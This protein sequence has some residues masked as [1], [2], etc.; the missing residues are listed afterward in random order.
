MKELWTYLQIMI[1]SLG[2]WLGW[3]LGGLDGFL[4]ALIIFV[5][6]DY[7][8]GLMVAIINRELSSEIGGRG[9]LK[10]LL[11]F[12]LVAIAHIIDSR[13]IGEGSIIR[14]AVIFFYLSNEGISIIENAA[15]I[16]LPVPQKLKDVLS[17]L[18]GE[19]GNKN[20]TKH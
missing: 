4:Y 6:V 13:L 9:I 10:K 2:G 8:T 12:I 18:H 14:T 20:E 3:F 16:G 7:I 17:Q 11:I 15:R 5:I 1:A 19:E